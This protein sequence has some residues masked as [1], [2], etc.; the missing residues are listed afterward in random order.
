MQKMGLKLR[1]NPIK[2]QTTYE[3]NLKKVS[4]QYDQSD[5]PYR[6]KLA[7]ITAGWLYYT[8][9]MAVY[10]LSKGDTLEEVVSLRW[11]GALAQI[12]FGDA[13]QKLRGYFANKME[14]Y[15]DSSNFRKVVLTEFTT[16]LTFPTVYT[17]VMAASNNLD[18]WESHLIPGLCV[19]LAVSP[20]YG[21]FSDTWRSRVFGLKEI[22]PRKM[23][24]SISRIKKIK[25]KNSNC[26]T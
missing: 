4:A 21:H 7:N 17:A 11:A 2:K 8:P 5:F 9:P 15:E 23:V 19:A 22:V 1:K 20:F 18:K 10:E 25:K 12:A 14:I 3:D 13:I 6:N 24:H 16:A 26:S